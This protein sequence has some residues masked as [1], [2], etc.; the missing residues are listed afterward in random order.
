MKELYKWWT[1]KE[2]LS[3]NS[4]KSHTQQEAL[5]IIMGTLE[6]EWNHTKKTVTNKQKHSSFIQTIIL[7]PR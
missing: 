3:H 5:L 6:H 4:Y 2:N 1:V 7:T